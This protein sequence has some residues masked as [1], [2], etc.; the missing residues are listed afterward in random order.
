MDLLPAKKTAKTNRHVIYLSFCVFFFE[1][2][3][4]LK[5][6]LAETFLLSSS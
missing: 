3:D 6:Y 1:F 5:C 2:S 4:S